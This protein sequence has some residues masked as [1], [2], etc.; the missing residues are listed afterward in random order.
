MVMGST[1]RTFINICIIALLLMFLWGLTGIKSESASSDNTTSS[2]DPTISTG[3]DNS[4]SRSS[5]NITSSYDPTISTGTG[6]STN[7]TS[8]NTTSDNSTAQVAIQHI[9]TAKFA[10]A[11]VAINPPST[12]PGNTVTVTAV[13]ANIGTAQGIYV[14]TLKINQTAEQT[15]QVS[16]AAGESQIVNFV[17]TRANAGQYNVDVNGQMSTF[18]VSAPAAAPTT[19]VASTTT[20]P[21][22]KPATFKVSDLTITPDSASTGDKGDSSSGSHQ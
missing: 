13:V 18:T 15:K 19:T 14:V 10:V 16:L 4:T 9:P 8:D 7:R 2:Y 12:S 6:S 17:T 11:S 1:Q 5:D 22:A 21:S 20:S 3:T